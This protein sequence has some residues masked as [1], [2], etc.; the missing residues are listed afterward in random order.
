M[1]R[2]SRRL[3]RDKQIST[4]GLVCS[5]GEDLL[6]Q[7]ATFSDSFSIANAPSASFPEAKTSLVG[8][9][10]Q[11]MERTIA[12]NLCRGVLEMTIRTTADCGS[13]E[14]AAETQVVPKQPQ[15]PQIFFSQ[16]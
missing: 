11:S 12:T 13:A 15:L 6:K 5:N 14:A 1:T 10:Q 7:L 2:G 8:S 3:N 16:E 4:E 9:C